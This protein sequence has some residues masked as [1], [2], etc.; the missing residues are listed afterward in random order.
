LSDELLSGSVTLPAAHPIEPEKGQQK[1][2]DQEKERQLYRQGPGN[3]TIP[4]SASTFLALIL[5]ESK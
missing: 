3:S 2:D 5:A 1:S 4:G